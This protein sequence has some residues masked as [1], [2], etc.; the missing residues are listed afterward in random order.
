[1]AE[2]ILLVPLFLSTWSAAEYGNWL[3]FSALVWFLTLFDLGMNT[4][5]ATRLTQ[6]YAQGA[7]DRYRAEQHSA[8]AFYLI[9]AGAGT[10]GW[11]AALF[12]FPSWR[13]FGFE[14]ALTP[15]TRWT[16]W[17]LGLQ[18][19]WILPQG[20]LLAVYRTI[21]DMATSQWLFN[22]RQILSVALVAL[23]LFFGAH[24]VAVAGIELAAIALAAGFTWWQIRRWCPVG[25][26][27]VSQAS[28]SGF[29]SLLRP[30]FSFWILNWTQILGQGLP[31]ILVRALVGEVAVATFAVSRTLITVLRQGMVLV[32][33]A[34]WPELTTIEARGEWERLR[35]LHR[36]VVIGSTAFSAAAVGILWF[37]G[38]ALIRLWTRGH[39][40]TD[41]VLLRLWLIHFAL[42][43]PW[44]ASALFPQAANRVGGFA[45]A[46]AISTL[47]AVLLS[48]ILM[49][50]LQSRA[51][52]L[53]FILGEGLVCQHF[54]IREICGMLKEPYVSFAR[55]LWIRWGILL[56]SALGAGWIVEKL[57][58]F[59]GPLHWFFLA[60]AV[61]SATLLASAMIL[62]GSR[63]SLFWL[64][65]Q[66]TRRCRFPG[67]E[68]LIAFL[69]DSDQKLGYRLHLT[70]PYEEMFRVKV[71]TAS[72][73]E[74]SLFF[75]GSYEPEIARLIKRYL[76]PGGV[77]LDAGA[78]VGLLTLVMSKCA[79]ERGR[80][81]SI[82]PH[83]EMFRKLQDH[84]EMNGLANVVPLHCALG[85]SAGRATLL[86]P[87]AGAPNSGSSTLRLGR[88]KDLPLPL[89]VEVKTLDD[90]IRIEKLNRLD[91]VK[92]DTE[93]YEMP[94]LR[95]GSS[96]LQRF[97]PIVIF[98][99]TVGN[100]ESI[101][102]SPEAFQDWF[103]KL[104]YR[105]F[106]IKRAAL[107]PLEERRPS[108]SCDL[109]ALPGGS[110]GHR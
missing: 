101:G 82:E 107:I 86:A 74:R 106:V 88:W 7:M 15:V 105:L 14:L 26:P 41:P 42:Q 37:I 68:R 16:L 1:M 28:F 66:V 78:N 99:Y 64:L 11:T 43:T 58:P 55:W 67:S 21:G 13:L 20:F 75:F 19:L 69:C 103:L 46:S 54:L 70:L 35:K 9:A 77:G 24:M 90:V 62:F 61:S 59:S 63:L 33:N 5:A 73:V 47:I 25:V 71:D 60:G 40:P 51:V 79:G 92:I 39:L 27:G 52:P 29:K 49:G 89:E 91:L 44:T 85:D 12:T 102:A 96:S 100:W 95:G 93:G 94:V 76:P 34:L 8:M 84:L 53:G 32:H 17:L 50:R 22:G 104:G 4:G 87:A 108:T 97:R 109:L 48:A 36:A 80:V 10:I 23:A 65:A 18:M 81:I 31:I 110:H 45:R 30:S 83:P 98:E 3:S 38:D 6:L 2:Q 72:C 57:H 56:G